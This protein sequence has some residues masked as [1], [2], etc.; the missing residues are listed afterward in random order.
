MLDKSLLLSLAIMSRSRLWPLHRLPHRLSNGC[1]RFGD[2]RARRQIRSAVAISFQTFPENHTELVEQ[3]L[4]GTLTFGSTRRTHVCTIV[5]VGLV[6]I[7]VCVA[8]VSRIVW[9]YFL[10][11]ELETV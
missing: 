7:G 2:Q 8:V 11:M 10:E 1:V 5:M 3:A 9:C 4:V 6:T